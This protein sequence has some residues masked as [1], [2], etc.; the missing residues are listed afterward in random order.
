[1]QAFVSRRAGRIG[2]GIVAAAVLASF[3]RTLAGELA[4]RGIRVNAISPGP[5][6]TPIY[7]QAGVS[8]AQAAERRARIA[9]AVPLR[10]LGAPDEIAGV[11]AFLASNDASF[12]TGQEIVVDGGL[13]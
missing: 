6:V 5:I 10:R 11:V 7:D 9:A 8:A 4:E 12:I 3:A 1:M 2:V 13:S